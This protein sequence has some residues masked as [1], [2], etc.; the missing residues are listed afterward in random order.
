MTSQLRRLARLESGTKLNPPETIDAIFS[1]V[2]LRLDSN[3]IR[4]VIL[5]PARTIQARPVCTLH[6]ASLTKDLSYT[7][8][9]RL[10]CTHRHPIIRSL[11]HEVV[12]PHSPRGC[13]AALK[14]RRPC[15][16]Q[17]NRNEY[18]VV[19]SKIASRH[20]YHCW[21]CVLVVHEAFHRSWSRFRDRF[22]RYRR[23]HWEDLIPARHDSRQLRRGLLIMLNH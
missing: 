14:K 8:G 18:A 23:S 21:F 17:Q 1:S 12:V 13:A 3:D 9:T 7:A 2:P 22:L 6:V 4:L 15:S 5:E 16:L 10:D 20:T 19:S 11:V